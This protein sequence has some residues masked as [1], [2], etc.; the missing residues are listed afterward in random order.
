MENFGENPGDFMLNAEQDA[1][2]AAE[3]SADVSAEKIAGIYAEGFINAVKAQNISVAD[4]AGE[5]AS[6]IAVLKELP[7]L[8]GI[9]ASAMV[10]T[11]EKIA[12]LEK[13]VARQATPLFW[14]FLQVVAR[15]NRLDLLF[16]IFVQTQAIVN[17]EQRR[18]PVVITTAAALDS[19]HLSS[20]A[21]KLKT[22][23]GG[24]PVIRTVVDPNVIGGLV[25]RV[26]DK[27]YD[28]SIAAQLQS[29][30]RK[31]IEQSAKDI[32]NKRKSFEQ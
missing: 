7:K 14:N 11:E 31:T 27:V 19:S 8:A 18:I 6:F 10:S 15:R 12:L 1:L 4:A 24:E 2:F 16:P 21:E 28:A 32:Q 29:I 30:C 9:L 17:R 23:I 5:L 26:G 20:L 25:V 3:F 13:A 22:V